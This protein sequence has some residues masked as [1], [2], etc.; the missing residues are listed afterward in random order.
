MPA[1]TSGAAG[2]STTLALVP[3][4]TP[5]GTGG[6]VGSKTTSALGLQVTAAAGRFEVMGAGILAAAVGVAA[7]L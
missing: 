1:G 3:E 7:L 5:V 2:R 4:T 6:G